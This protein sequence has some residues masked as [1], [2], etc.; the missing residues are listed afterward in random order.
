MPPLEE[1]IIN[2]LEMRA[3]GYCPVFHREKRNKTANA[4]CVGVQQRTYVASCL[5]SALE[6]IARSKL[7]E[8]PLSEQKAAEY[9]LSKRG[10]SS[11][12]S[13]SLLAL[14]NKYYSAK[15]RREKLSL[16]AL[17]TVLG[18]Q[19]P[20]MSVARILDTVGLERLVRKNKGRV[21]T[22]PDKKQALKIAFDLDMPAVDVAYFLG[23]RD[24][25]VRTEFRRA[26]KCCSDRLPLACFERGKIRRHLSYRLASQIY[27]ALDEGFSAKETAELTGVSK[28]VLEFAVK[29]RA[30]YEPKIVRTLRSLYPS[31]DIKT[32]YLP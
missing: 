18:I 4:H 30:E 6:Q 20:G 21:I 3:S 7:P 19:H 24:Y 10:K 2:I 28:S 12:S 16:T 15:Q 17:G 13:Q 27:E 32:P 29:N 1:R 31:K 22:P 25:V 5:V 11:Y 9:L 26:G 14:F 8:Q 23:L